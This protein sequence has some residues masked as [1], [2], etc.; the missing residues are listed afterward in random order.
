MPSHP[1]RPTSIQT[2]LI[3]F[4]YSATCR[5]APVYDLHCHNFYELYFFL[6]GDADYLVEGHHYRPAPESLL[7]LAPH[8]FHGVRVNTDSEYRRFALHFHPDLL[9]TEHRSFLLSVFPSPE[10]PQRQIYFEEVGRWDLPAYFRAML[11]CASLP[12][13]LFDQMLPISMESLLSRILTMAADC[14]PLSPTARSAG[15]ISDLILYLNRHLQEPITLDDLSRRFFIS[16]HHLNKVFRKATGTTVVDYLLHKRV[17][18]AQ[19]LLM[20]GHS[21][22]EA[23]MQAGFG[24]YSSFYRSY[25]RILG[26]SPLKDRGSLPPFSKPGDGMKWVK[27]REE[28]K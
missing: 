28:I 24:D 8:V 19:Q 22:Q 25:R 13:A 18:L 16:K 7:L 5:A 23:A 4:N 21:A 1:S 12:E 10:Q 17:T 27:L 14:A 3:N 9:T 6:N 2:P 15:S 20:E 26:H 11:D